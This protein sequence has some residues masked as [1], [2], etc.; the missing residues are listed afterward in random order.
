MREVSISQLWGRA[1][2][3]FKV[4]WLLFVGLYILLVIVIFISLTALGAALVFLISPLF[5]I[6]LTGFLILLTGFLIVLLILTPAFVRA[7]YLVARQG[8]SS[9][10]EAFRDLSSLLKIFVYELT[11]LLILWIL[12]SIAPLGWGGLDILIVAGFIILFLSFFG[13]A[14]PYYVLSG[15]AGIFS[16]IGQSF[17][18]T[19]RNFSKVFVAL[20]SVIGLGL[21]LLGLLLLG[22]GLLMEVPILILGVE[23][24]CGL[25]LLV[26]LPIASI[27]LPL[28]YLALT[29]EEGVSHA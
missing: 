14:A 17:S 26:V 19:W 28:L 15:R 8:Q 5:V 12:L 7:G 11:L 29:D 21:L 3:L 23:L 27:F 25:G 2:D 1:W 22:L 24:L 18:L 20:L 10:G 4:N 13:W 16:A 6:G 9:F